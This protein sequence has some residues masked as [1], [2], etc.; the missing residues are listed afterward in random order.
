MCL[1]AVSRRSS[2]KKIK[3]YQ[4]AA[5]ASRSRSK[6]DQEVSRSKQDQEVSRSKQDQ[7]VSRIKQIKRDRERQK[8]R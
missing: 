8:Q 7:E 6:H 2:I 4:E 1:A 5:A 3:K